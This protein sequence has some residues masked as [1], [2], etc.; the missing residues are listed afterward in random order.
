MVLVGRARVSAHTACA[1][2]PASHGSLQNEILSSFCYRPGF[3]ASLI[4]RHR[5]EARQELRQ[6]PTGPLLH[7]SR[8]QASAPLVTRWGRGVPPSLPGARRGVPWAQAG[9]CVSWPARPWAQAGG[10]VSWPARPLV[11]STAGATRHLHFCS[12]VLKNGHWG[13]GLLV[14]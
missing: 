2:L 7:R 8:R 4:H 6:G 9:G 13:V 3:L 10:C 12:W 5:L 14:S 1:L 11:V